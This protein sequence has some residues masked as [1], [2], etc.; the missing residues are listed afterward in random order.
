MRSSLLTAAVAAV[1]VAACDRPDALVICHNANCAEP[2]DPA[3][4]DTLGALRESLALEHDG[5][6]AIDGIELDSF[7]RGS[8]GV[9]LYA[10]DL[11]N[12]DESTLA[13]EPA[14]E[15]AAHFA[16]PGPITYRGGA[17][18]HVLLELKSHVSA[19]TTDRHTPE[20]RALHAQCAW[21]IY[22]IISDAAIANGRDVEVS[23]EAFAPELLRAVLDARPAATPTPF[24]LG[25]VQGVPA[26]LDDQ[27]RPLG[28][29]GDLPIGI[30][31]FHAQW[32]LDAQ[33]EAFASY[34]AAHATDAA[35]VDL[36]LFM[37]SATVE[38]FGVI[39]QYE[40]SLIVTSEA[41]LFRRWLER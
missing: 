22:T 9:C 25:A 37:F 2:A 13:I 40:P 33:Y 7:F 19:S 6:P 3:Q 15:L 20:Q 27:T 38:T 29:Y 18:F 1:A 11:A 36:A 21:D 28:D 12:P 41:R 26:P 14:M 32:L 24:R 39:E 35:P 23:F 8:D 30:F 16:E 34:R 4:D 17:R 5:R 31:E 10:H